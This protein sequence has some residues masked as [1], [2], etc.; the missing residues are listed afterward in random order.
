MNSAMHQPLPLSVYLHLPWCQSKCPYCDFNS[1]P[2]HGELP[3][4]AYVK[5]LA[6]DMDGNRRWLSNRTIHS[7]FFGGGTP[8]LFSARSIG[9]LLKGLAAHSRL[10]D[11]AE[12]TLEANPGS[13]EVARFCDYRTAGVNR[14]SLGIQSF[15]DASLKA[16]GR[17][18][19]AAQACAAI[20]AAHAAGFEAINLDLMHCLPGQRLPE[21]LRDLDTALSFA[22]QHLSLYQLTIEPNTRFAAQPP[23][24]PDEDTAWAICAGIE[25]KTAAAGLQHYEVSAF[26]RAGSQCRHNLNYWQFGDYLGFGAGAHSK[27]TTADAIRRWWRPRHPRDYMRTAERAPDQIQRVS[28]NELAFEFLLNALRLKGGFSIDLFEERTRLK[29]RGIASAVDKATMRGLLEV[30]GRQILA[31][32]HGWRFLD[33]LLQD[34]LPIGMGGRSACYDAL[35]PPP[36]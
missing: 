11:S 14:L 19:D 3:Q 2:L 35:A 31:T 32:E 1:H 20:D 5:A 27:V 15:N 23:R 33:D 29:W 10:D 22:P 18:H 6:A 17:I 16:L 21:A 30:R 36:G 13:A 9:Q 28:D 4:D 34:F 12:I 25:E 26:A 7:V 24:L 8:S